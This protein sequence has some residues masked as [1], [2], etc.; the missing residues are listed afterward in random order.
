M[1]APAPARRPRRSASR[2]RAGALACLSLAL[3][4]PSLAQLSGV[5]SLASDERYRG[6]SVSGGQ[7][8]ASVALAWDFSASGAYAG[9]EL[10]AAI[11][12]SLGSL[13]YAGWAARAGPTTLD[14]GA[15]HIV[16]PTDAAYTYDAGG[17][18]GGR[19]DT[20][21]YAGARLGTVD[22]Y[23]YYSPD[24]FG[25]G[26]G[27]AYF[28]VG[29][30]SPAIG[31]LRLHGRL[32]LDQPVGGGAWAAAGPSYDARAGLTARF[33]AA[34]LSL[35]GTWLWGPG[36]QGAAGPGFVASMNYGF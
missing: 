35:D 22:A 8:A 12:G 3:A 23:L 1:T 32:G 24:Y 17:Y 28:T 25:L 7:P 18:R 30:A 21:L 4:R 10:T 6:A 29:A 9:A 5:A 27:A 36:A 34:R 19:G 26:G 33:G 2:I 20:Q 15:L 16:T 14:L 11:A 13:V 31:P